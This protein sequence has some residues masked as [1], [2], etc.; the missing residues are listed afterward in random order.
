MADD[1][2]RR[3]FAKNLNYYIALRGF[4]SSY[5]L[6]R[7]YSGKAFAIYLSQ[8]KSPGSSPGGYKI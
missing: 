3:I 2:E 4:D 6:L 1:N 8:K 5:L 7:I